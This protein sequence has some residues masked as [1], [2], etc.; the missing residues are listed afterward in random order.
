[1]IDEKEE[2]F[3]KSLTEAKGVP[4][5]EGE[6]RDIFRKTARPWA[7]DIETDGLGSIV[8]RHTGKSEKP[9]ILFASHLDEV[10]FMV[11]RI[12][13]KGFIAF[14]PLGGWF[15]QVLLAQQV[16]ITNQSGKEYL[17]VIAS[18]P[19]H[20]LSAEERKK[21]FEMKKMFID[22][23]ASSKKEVLEWGISPGDTITPYMKY[24]RLNSSKYLLAK[25]WDNR[26][27]TAITL[28]VF[29]N[30]AKTE[31][32]NTILAGANVQEEV[33]LRGART[34]TNMTKPDIA[35]AIDTGIAGDTPEI[36]PEEADAILGK[37]P[38]IVLLDASIVAH[39]GLRNFVINTAEELKIPYQPSFIMGGGTDAGMMHLSNNGVPSIAITVPTRYLHSHA[40][41]IHEDDY[42]S[43][44]KLV[45]EV[46]KRLDQ[47][48]VAKLKNY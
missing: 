11:E 33:G 44:I 22:I 5:D 21:P 41:I 9:R 35:F 31:H 30:L 32:P 18:K 46:I 12:T 6:V 1:M 43:T 29:E 28:R 24:R 16:I 39:S 45:T 47:D 15:D 48:R 40:S 13:D 42:L 36:K 20:I 17:G 8:A 10:G 19:P 26:I 38:Q 4:G 14:K 27:G 2:L 3:L 34:L 25:A 23:G 37:G 7:D